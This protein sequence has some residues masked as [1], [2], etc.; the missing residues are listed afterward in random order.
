MKMNIKIWSLLL[1]TPVGLS[2]C[3]ATNPPA[4]SE[5]HIKPPAEISADIPET[6]STAP[7]LPAPQP[8]PDLETYTVIV[9]QVPVRELLFSMARD[10]KLNLDIDNDINGQVTMNAID[11]TLPKILERLAS[12]VAINYQLEGETLHVMADK[13]YLQMYEIDYLNMS[14]VSTG[15]VVVS[16]EISSTGA[17][18]DK[19]Q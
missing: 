12:Q 6:V 9:N 2:G 1:T 13:P 14:R 19:R 10:A 4:Q 7:A 18:A 5:G 17:G 11:Q 16:T 3:G 15:N 8:R